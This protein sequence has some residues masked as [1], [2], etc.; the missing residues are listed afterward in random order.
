MSEHG[1]SNV[2]TDGDAARV[3]PL[4][5]RDI[6][7]REEFVRYVL[8]AADE[9]HRK[10]LGDLYKLWRQWNAEFFGGEE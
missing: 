6:E 10:H 7:H 2:P 9:W 3:K 8:E 4:I 5:E 1:K